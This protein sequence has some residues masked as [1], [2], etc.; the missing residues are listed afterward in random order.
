MANYLNKEG[1]VRDSL[2]IAHEDTSPIE[3]SAPI[4]ILKTPYDVIIIFIK[5]VGL[6]TFPL[7]FN[8]VLHYFIVTIIN[9]KTTIRIKNNKGGGERETFSSWFM[10]K[11]TSLLVILICSFAGIL[12]LHSI[13]YNRPTKKKELGLAL[14]PVWIIEE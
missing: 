10:R 4:F 5:I 12:S 2:L 8:N 13:A 6:F 7:L 1:I 3:D 14:G 11:T 9:N